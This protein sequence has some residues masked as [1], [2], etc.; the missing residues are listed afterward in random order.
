MLNL[1][2]DDCDRATDR[3]VPTR[4][5][6]LLWTGHMFG[7]GIKGAELSVSLQMQR[8]QIDVFAKCIVKCVH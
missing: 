4:W 5:H 8:A 1:H 6:L 2:N 7:S 3:L